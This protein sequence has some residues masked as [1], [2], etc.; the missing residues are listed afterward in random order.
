MLILINVLF[1]YFWSTPNI[2]TW[3][4]VVA[5][6]RRHCQPRGSQTAGLR[7]W[8]MRWLPQDLKPLHHCWLDFKKTVRNLGRNLWCEN[9]WVRVWSYIS[10]TA[11]DDPPLSNNLRICPWDYLSIFL[12]SPLEQ[13]WTS[14]DS[15]RN[16]SFLAKSILLRALLLN[17]PDTCISPTP[18]PMSLLSFR[19]GW[20]RKDDSVD[21]Q[22]LWEMSAVCQ[23]LMN[24]EVRKQPRIVAEVRKARAR[25]LGFVLRL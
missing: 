7:Y 17:D 2:W 16:L 4:T 15:Q 6:A 20:H 22:H 11:P 18:L 12:S 21:P 14:G 8:G 10:V 13:L 23:T 24:R 3:V 5:L 25:F 19:P 1:I 9:L